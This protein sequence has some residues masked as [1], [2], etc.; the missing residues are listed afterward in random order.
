MFAKK[1]GIAK[2]WAKKYGVRKGLPEHK[3]WLIMAEDELVQPVEP[4]EEE[5]GDEWWNT[6]NICEL[7][8]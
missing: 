2:R 8:R 5:K 1:P 6:V 4:I 7:K 3:G